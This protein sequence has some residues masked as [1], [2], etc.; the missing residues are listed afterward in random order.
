MKI[1]NFE[2]LETDILLIV[3]IEFIALI[4]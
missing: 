3:F 2:D 1:E 4:D